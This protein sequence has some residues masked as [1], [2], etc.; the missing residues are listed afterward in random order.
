MGRCRR[1]FVHGV[2]PRAAGAELA[3]VDVVLFSFLILFVFQSG[4][5]GPKIIDLR[6][7]CCVLER[8]SSILFHLGFL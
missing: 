4:R 2:D 8:T 5:F 1:I 7:I 3:P 6:A